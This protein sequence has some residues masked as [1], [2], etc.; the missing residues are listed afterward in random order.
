MSDIEKPLVL[1]A[2]VGGTRARLF[3]GSVHANVWHVLRCEEIPCAVHAGVEALIEAFLGE[4]GERPGVAC[5]AVAGALEGQHIRMTN[6]PWEVDGE[7]LRERFGFSRVCLINDFAAQVHG[8]ACLDKEGILVLQP[9]DPDTQGVRALIG[10]G[11]GLGMAV[12]FGALD[13]LLV[14]PSQGGL[15]DF[16]PRDAR[17]LALCES[18]LA[19]YGRVS[20]EMLLSGHG[21]ER[22]YRFV[23]GLPPGVPLGKDAGAIGADALAGEAIA[24]E[25]L[26]FFARLL[27]AAAANLGLTVLARGG[28]YLTGGIVARI[29]P[30]LRAPE[31]VD[32]FR[33]HPLMGAVLARIPLYAVCDELLGLKGA[34]QIAARLACDE[35]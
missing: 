22:L 8:L 31:F 1:A 25:A 34:A 35:N 14:L 33:E 11:T 23:A 12:S 20:I 29:L 6:L 30:F 21:I 7:C 28:V 13:H 16:A 3:L 32:L 9:G 10:P 19:E 26:Q 2:D 4:C 24:T 5:L 15:A 27:V 18:L 17:E